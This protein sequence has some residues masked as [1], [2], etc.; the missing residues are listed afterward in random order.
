MLGP[1]YNHSDALIN[2]NMQYVLYSHMKRKIQQFEKSRSHLSKICEN[3]TLGKITWFTI[4]LLVRPR[5]FARDFQSATGT[6]Y[7]Y[8][9]IGIV[10][11]QSLAGRCSKL[12]AH[13]PRFLLHV[14]MNL[15]R[16][17]P[18]YGLRIYDT[19]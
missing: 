14:I 4:I 5:P 10:A 12:V 18:A 1:S 17:R 11:P 19:I 3:T 8:A 6:Q 15:L 2:A 7:L 9:C 16:W 13:T